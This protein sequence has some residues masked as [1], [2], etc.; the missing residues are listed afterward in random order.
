MLTSASYPRDSLFHTL[1]VDCHAPAS[2]GRAPSPATAVL[3]YLVGAGKAV[4]VDIRGDSGSGHVGAA[5][6][7]DLGDDPELGI[8]QELRPVS[9]ERERSAESREINEPTKGQVCVFTT[10]S[11]D[12]QVML[13]LASS[14]ATYWSHVRQTC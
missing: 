14:S 10:T 4:G 9:K 3:S 1:G 2:G 6:G 8:V 13:S 5:N 7:F 12:I 11:Q